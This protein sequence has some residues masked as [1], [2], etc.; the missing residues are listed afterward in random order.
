MDFVLVKITVPFFSMKNIQRVLLFKRNIKPMC[1]VIFSR[2]CSSTAAR[3]LP[4]YPCPAAWPDACP[5][6]G[7]RSACHAVQWTAAS[8]DWLPGP[9]T[10]PGAGVLRPG[11]AGPGWTPR[12]AVSGRGPAVPSPH[13][14]AATGLP[15]GTGIHT[16]GYTG[17]ELLQVY[18]KC[19]KLT[20]YCVHFRT[21]LVGLSAALST[22]LKHS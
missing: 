5:A 18:D 1:V 22:L 2:L 7:R 8:P 4:G 3:L 19:F 13:H 11:A 15:A 21:H 10:G 20:V 12:R 16:G 9:D 14:P 17:S 6:A